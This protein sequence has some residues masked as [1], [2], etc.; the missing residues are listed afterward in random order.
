[1]VA[2]TPAP[3]PCGTRQPDPDQGVELCRPARRQRDMPPV[4]FTPLQLVALN[5]PDAGTM[6]VL[7]V[8][9]DPLVRAGLVALLGAQEGY[10]VTGS[11]AVGDGLDAALDRHRPDVVLWDL[12]MAEPP[13]LELEAF[14]EAGVPVVALLPD[15]T[16]AADAWAA[17]ARGLLLRNASPAMMAAALVAAQQGLVVVDPD[18]SDA[19]VAF[20]PPVTAGEDLTPREQDVLALL[21]E[22]LP[23]KLIADRLGISERTV[24][25]HV[26]AI[27]SKFGVH[28][29]T[30]AVLRGARLGLLL[31]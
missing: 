14:A 19:A 17:G 31:L 10:A 5:V 9:G 7:V 21:A 3:A 25:F 1:M 8:A 24:K 2:A 11:A 12:G 6:R 20:R 22:G 26:A 15:E 27:L 18:L 13:A 16:A 23:N 30:E 28:S 29:R 4:V